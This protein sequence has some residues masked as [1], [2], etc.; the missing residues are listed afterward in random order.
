MANSGIH[1]TFSLGATAHLT[2]NKII[3]ITWKNEEPIRTE[4][5]SLM[6]EKLQAATELI[7]KKL[8]LKHIEK[9]YS[10][11]TPI[12]VIKKEI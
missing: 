12:F 1:S 5:W 10:W 7:H 2:N 4:Q 8:E 6:K 11:N 9:S 3:K